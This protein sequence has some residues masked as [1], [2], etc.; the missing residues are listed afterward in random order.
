MISESHLQSFDL[1]ISSPLNKSKLD[2][3]LKIDSFYVILP[4]IN[5]SFFVSVYVLP[6][7]E[8]KEGI[9]DPETKDQLIRLWD[10]GEARPFYEQVCWKCQKHT[11]YNKWKK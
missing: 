9:A 8:L 10:L 2:F 7:F 1:K 5:I 11:D 4:F 3:D 6:T